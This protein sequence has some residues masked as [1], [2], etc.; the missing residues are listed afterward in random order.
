MPLLSM[1][2]VWEEPWLVVEELQVRSARWGAWLGAWKLSVSTPEVCELPWLAVER[3]EDRRLWCDALPALL[4]LARERLSSWSMSRS[5]ASLMYDSR[6][7]F[8]SERERQRD[9]K[10]VV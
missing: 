9:R 2:D 3:R 6:Y 7:C 10:S 8:L 4:P 1:P 5:R